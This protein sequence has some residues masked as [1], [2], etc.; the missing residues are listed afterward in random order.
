MSFPGSHQNQDQRVKVVAGYALQQRLGSGSF[1][2]VYKGIRVKQQHPQSV[3]D[4]D[5]NDSSSA[6]TH[7][8]DEQEAKEHGNSHGR[9]PSTV[10][11]K[12]I[13][14]SSEKL[15]KKVLQNLE[16]EI[17]IL[18]T[19]RHPNIVCMH[20]VQKTDRHF[21]LLLEYCGGGDVQHLIRS[22]QKGRLSE[23]LTR[24]LMRDLASGLRFL[25]GQEL[26]HRDIKPQNLLLT[27]PLPMEELAENPP[28][29]NNSGN[30][31]NSRS[32]HDDPNLGFSL[33]I[34]DFGFA[35]HLQTASLA[36]TLCGSPL[37]MAPE[38]LQH[39]RYDAKAD[40]W[41]VGT[42]LFEMIAGRP[43]FNGENH[44]DL[45]RNIQ[46]KAVRLPPTVRVSK[47]CVNLLR[48]LLNRNPLS[49]AGFKEFF[50]ACDVFVA[51]GC[52]GVATGDDEGGVG[53]NRGVSTKGSGTNR[54]VTTTKD[55]G[56]IHENDHGGANNPSSD[57]LMTIS[58]TAEQQ[59]QQHL[60]APQKSVQGQGET[61]SIGINT[62]LTATQQGQQT[63][64]QQPASQNT[65]VVSPNITPLATPP[66]RAALIPNSIS[67]YSNSNA[68]R[69]LTSYHAPNNRNRLAPLTSSPP[70]SLR[71]IFYPHP[72]SRPPPSLPLQTGAS[73]NSQQHNPYQQQ[74]MQQPQTSVGYYTPGVTGLV[75]A[76]TVSQSQASVSDDSGFVMVEHTKSPNSSQHYYATSSQ[77]YRSSNVNN[78][79]VK[80]SRAS[81]GMLSTS[82]GTGKL[83]LG[84][85]GRG[86]IGFGVGG[87]SNG[88]TSA[89]QLS[90]NINKQK[91]EQTT[92]MSK[93]ANEIAAA[94]KMIATAEDVGRR[95][96]SVAHLGDSRAYLGMRLLFKTNEEGSS[97][98]SSTPMEGVEEEPSLK[99]TTSGNSAVNTHV[100][101]TDHS[102][103]DMTST[104]RRP[105][106]SGSAD[107]QM[108]ADDCVEDE[109][110]FA[111]S[112]DT[113]S[114]SLPSRSDPSGYNRSTS[115]L[116]LK[117]SSA[118][119]ASP[120][121][122]RSRFGEALSCYLKSLKML[123]GAVGASQR[124]AKDL[125]DVEDQ[126]GKHNDYRSRTDIDLP[127]MKHRSE[128]TTHWL[129]SQFR[130]VLERADAANVEI[131][132]LTI[133]GANNTDSTGNKEV[134]KTTNSVS[135]EE[136]IYNHALASGRD[137]A[138]KQLLGQYEAARSCYRSAGLLAET[139]LMEVNIGTDDRK[140]LEGYV[141]GFAARITELDQLM[142]QQ[143]RMAISSNTTPSQSQQSRRGSGI[144]GLIGPPSSAPE[145]SSPFL[146]G[147]PR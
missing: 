120:E 147:S 47:A 92:R 145:T 89:A 52:G 84:M 41:S 85:I 82:P 1:A 66:G 124:V 37:Y 64:Q 115:I 126:I 34:A 59:Q 18:R 123:K 100:L 94:N 107:K 93:L 26:I 23:R 40:L 79:I 83:L 57:S 33:K 142:L 49:R 106:T 87:G 76:N 68:P 12:A 77:Q 6:G 98:L 117:K 11:I 31:S 61:S 36:E 131:S 110:P 8:Q 121:N 81:K 50:E 86:T 144:V 54:I 2:T 116:G 55:L 3:F 137:G 95:A 56:T 109:M 17:S 105:S 73:N 97:L 90:S 5:E 48:L 63:R 65:N 29:S 125:K 96:V 135:V 134:N 27:G 133:S 16:I 39:H 88:N 32:I 60:P 141:D 130:G 30:D 129:C 118:V 112:P 62:N 28:I 119:S 67:M 7:R 136:L 143:S 103:S 70:S 113:P 19:Y 22:R 35:R 111:I 24:R 140:I 51:L 53:R 4:E 71:P 101:S 25:W 45:L 72:H 78:D 128:I 99:E 75:Q 69:S 146:I 15:T 13:T 139:L 10:A 44:I 42:V 132:K 14:R 38:I 20:D 9:Q 43:P 122:I 46:R 21:Y 102:S 138:V 74:H 58:T 104:R 114:V 91:V 127:K 80:N 108:M